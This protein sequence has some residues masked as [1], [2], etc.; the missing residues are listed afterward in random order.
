MPSCRRNRSLRDKESLQRVA[1][2]TAWPAAGTQKQARD[3]YFT[4]VSC[5][6]P[7]LFT[8]RFVVFDNPG[9]S[10]DPLTT[11][12]PPP[13]HLADIY[14]CLCCE[15]A[16][17][18]RRERFSAGECRS[19]IQNGEQRAVVLLCFLHITTVVGTQGYAREV[20]C[21]GR[22]YI[23][24]FGESGHCSAEDYSQIPIVKN[25]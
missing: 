9:R 22:R 4:A 5:A 14:F 6:V 15:Y 20:V 10:V 16:N 17:F 11:P 12:P 21:F 13:K 7:I 8:R 19:S 1:F 24:G 2:S 23:C 18:L 3:H 25:V